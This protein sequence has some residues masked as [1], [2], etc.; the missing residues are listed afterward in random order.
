MKPIFPISFFLLAISL[1]GQG[2]E[3]T[4][5]DSTSSADSK[6]KEILAPANLS[7]VNSAF[8]DFAPYVSAAGDKLYFSSNRKGNQEDFYISEF[9]EM[10]W[11]KPYPLGPPINTNANEGSMAISAD[12]NLIVFTACGRTDSYGGC[13]LFMSERVV[14]GWSE[15]RNLGRYVNSSSWDGHP[16]ISADGKWLYFSSDRYGGFGSRD[17]WRS[18]RRE[19]TWG[20]P[21]NLGYPINNARDQA[22]PIIH[23][24]GVTLYFSSAGH[25]GLGMLDIFKAEMDST[26]K[27]GE[28]V[29]L[30]PPVNT[31]GSD[32]FF[33]I[34]AKGDLIYFS[35]DRQG[36]Y[37]GYDVYWLPLS[38][39]LRPKIVA[40]LSG[41]V[42]DKVTGKP[43]LA[44][45][46]V[47][48]I[49]TGEVLATPK[50]NPET[51]EFFLVLPAGETYGISVSAEG[52][53]FSSERYNVPVEE[54]YQ[55]LKVNFELTRVKVGESIEIRNIFFDFNSDSLKPESKSELQR[56]LK[57]LTEYPNMH[58]EIEGHA[59][60]VGTEAYNLRLSQRRAMAV[61]RWLV[62]HGIATKRLKAVG[63]GE[64]LPATDNVSEDGRQLNRRT[65]FKIIGN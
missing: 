26:G 65:E 54:G 52:Y 44:D 29:N 61:L 46:T 4:V 1:L 45:I 6:N 25:G 31:P 36:G 42:A 19:G 62:D 41:T 22:C 56:A 34:P 28:P 2:G 38:E 5:A 59:D 12:G 49:M 23:H 18:P 30:G 35:S 57:L 15:P 39:A 27:W 63:Y 33:S 64:S 20:K 53:V 47:E 17:I 11:H 37:G 51:G 24:D 9:T 48:N 40:T 55:E 32:N 8:S 13:D 60:S 21:E 43:L 14:G 10:K 50:T 3:A 16:S 7:E 58:I